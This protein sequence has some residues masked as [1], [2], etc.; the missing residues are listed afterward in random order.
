MEIVIN[1]KGSSLSKKTGGIRRKI[2]EMNS[3][4]IVEF[5][6]LHNL[7][8]SSSLEENCK[9][10]AKQ[11]EISRL[12][13]NKKKKSGMTPQKF[14]NFED[15]EVY[16]E[17]LERNFDEMESE[18]GFS[19]W[20]SNFSD[21]R[22]LHQGLGV[23]FENFSLKKSL[24]AIKNKVSGAINSAASSKSV[25]FLKDDAKFK[26]APL[27]K[28]LTG[29]ETTYE[30]GVFQK[31]AAPLQKKMEGVVMGQLLGG[32][33]GGSGNGTEGSGLVE[34]PVEHA[35]LY[36]DVPLSTVRDNVVAVGAKSWLSSD[37]EKAIDELL[38]KSEEDKERAKIKAELI[39]IGVD[40][41]RFTNFAGED[42]DIPKAK[43]AISD[44]LT[45]VIEGE[46]AKATMGAMPKIALLVVVAL[47]AGYLVKKYA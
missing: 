27:K 43:Q 12:A 38:K 5:L 4:K 20:E 32:A 42:F 26:V 9:R 37:R 29:K 41:R 19:G 18:I 23:G 28:L 40:P 44:L 21:F 17:L 34:M 39:R 45:G 1:P 3:D 11:Y 35:P 16:D 7:P 33:L 13:F 22:N 14:A 30:T 24:G 8:I 6:K 47:V 10:V 36:S 15:T 31:L 46:K 2:V 25:A